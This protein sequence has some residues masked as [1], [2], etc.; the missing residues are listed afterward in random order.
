[1]LARFVKNDGESAGHPKF[2]SDVNPRD[3][4][5]RLSRSAEA[6]ADTPRSRTPPNMIVLPISGNSWIIGKIRS[7]EPSR[8]SSEISAQSAAS[9]LGRSAGVEPES[10]LEF[11]ADAMPGVAVAVITDQE[12]QRAWDQY[13]CV[14]GVEGAMR[15]G[16]YH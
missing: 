16:E 9:R 4:I 12:M 15:G 6:R 2:G 14:R 10:G 1:V 7:D 8:A 11:D 5:C 13:R 3:T